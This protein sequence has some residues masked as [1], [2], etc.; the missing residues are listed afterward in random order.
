[1]PWVEA[2]I[3]SSEIDVEPFNDVITRLENMTTPLTLM[4]RDIVSGVVESFA[5]EGASG[6]KAWVPLTPVYGNWKAARG[7]GVP[8][9]VG[10]RRRGPKG[11]RPQT[12]SMS[13]EM[14][15]DLLADEAV[16]VTPR[17][18]AYLPESNIAGFHQEG[19]PK[20]A[21]RPP[22][23]LLERELMDWDTILADWVSGV[24]DE[25]GL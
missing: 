25:A 5:T 11:Q 16:K 12:Y 10:L 19:T 4:G 23:P 20:M 15:R 13:G 2:R 18:L 1:M 8:K 6:G 9:L 24:L 3:T 21:A 17:T 22:V 14:E 7:P